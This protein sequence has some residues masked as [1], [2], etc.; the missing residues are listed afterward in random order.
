M[1]A[2]NIRASRASGGFVVT[3]CNVVYAEGPSFMVLRLV[4]GATLLQTL[5]SSKPQ[6]YE[7]QPYVELRPGYQ[8]PQPR[9]ARHGRNDSLAQLSISSIFHVLPLMPHLIPP[10]DATTGVSG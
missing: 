2:A 3:F 9:L 5:G 6:Q 10:P 1:A 8:K 7:T 4:L